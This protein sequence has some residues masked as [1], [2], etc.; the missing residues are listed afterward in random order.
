MKRNL[1]LFLLCLPV[2]AFGQRFIKG[3]VYEE[4]THFPLS[5]A[6]IRLIGTDGSNVTIQTDSLGYYLIDSNHFSAKINY[7]ISAK[8]SLQPIYFESDREPITPNFNMSLD[9]LTKN[10]ALTEEIAEHCTRFPIVQFPENSFAFSD[11]AKDSLSY[12]Y[13]WLLNNPTVIIQIDG[14]CD[15]K[16]KNPLELSQARAMACRDYFISKGIDSAR[17][18]VKGWGSTRPII[19][20]KQIRK[21][22]KQAEKDSLSQLNRRIEFEI[23][24]WDYSKK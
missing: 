21:V 9:T 15:K 2:L 12:L 6:T 18:A 14:H 1:L 8:R 17:L 16:E 23:L 5:N 24:R 7:L 19:Q 20:Q 4:K 10:F 3:H 22:K 13:K 11:G